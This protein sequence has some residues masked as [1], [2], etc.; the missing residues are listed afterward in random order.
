MLERSWERAPEEVHHL[1]AACN[2][3]TLATERLPPPVHR[4]LGE[5]HHPVPRTFRMRH[6]TP[7]EQALADRRRIQAH[8]LVL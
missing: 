7:P 8:A 3:A 5:V 1:A 4:F 2:D 6:R